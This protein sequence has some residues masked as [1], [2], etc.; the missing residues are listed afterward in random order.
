[1]GPH[2]CSC[3]PGSC[4]AELCEAQIDRFWTDG[5]PRH[6]SPSDCQPPSDGPTDSPMTVSCLSI[7][8]ILC[9]TDEFVT[10]CSLMD[11]AGIYDV[12]NSD[13]MTFFAPTNTA[14]EM[15]PEK[16]A[17]AVLTDT[18]L[19]TFILLG[20][21]VSNQ[22]LLTTRD[23]VCEDGLIDALSMANEEKNTIQC[24]ESER[25]PGRNTLVVGG[26]NSEDALTTVPPPMIIGP[27]VMACNGI[28]HA[29]D[30]V[31]LP[32]IT[33]GRQFCPCS[34]GEFCNFDLG[35]TG[36]CEPCLS[37]E[38]ECFND[39]LPDQGA[40]DCANA[41]GYN[42]GPM[43]A[44]PSTAPVVINPTDAP[45]VINPTDA[46]VG[47]PV[48]NPTAAPITPTTRSTTSPT[49]RPTKKKTQKKQSKKSK[50]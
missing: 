23:F 41:C 15:L 5:C 35:D 39:N 42:D 30:G 14:F 17:D 40:T 20:H 44:S 32:D 18:E 7:A 29:L 31:I 12:L 28:L 11:T 45:V 38:E 49:T 1:M 47:P 34:E 46:P 4:T 13:T 24:M 21:V 27:N 8:E 43:S 10:L 26:G 9:T 16:I 3:D 2:K 50:K 48:P 22:A 37:S 25:N 36:F 19:L 6:C 33:D